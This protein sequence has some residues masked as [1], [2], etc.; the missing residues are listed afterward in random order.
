MR[1]DLHCHTEA[2]HDCSSQFDGV[3]TRCRQQ[4]IAVQAVTD[5]D[6]IWGALELREKSTAP[7]DPLI[8][9]GEEVTTREGEIIG[10]FLEELIPADLSPEEVVERIREQGGLVLLP[11]GF[12]PLKTHRL[13]PAARERIAHEIDI[14]EVFNTRVSHPRRNA[15]ASQWAAE[16]DLPASAGTDAHI[17]PALGTAWVETPDRPIEG[18][19]DLL[20]ALRAGAISGTWTHPVAAYAYK[21][22]DRGR[23]AAYRGWKRVSGETKALIAGD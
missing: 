13:S 5:H 7:G 12:D 1:I 4:R 10:L 17:V 16:R 2:S 22:W 19:E 9:V 8:I 23:R 11:H 3:I 18:P 15:Q 21:L 20:A 6:Q 14:V